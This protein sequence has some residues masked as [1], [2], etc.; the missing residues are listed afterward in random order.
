M[1]LSASAGAQGFEAASIKPS[2]TVS[3]RGC[4][5]RNLRNPRFGGFYEV[6]WN[7]VARD[8]IEPP[9]PAFSGLL[10]D[11]AKRFGINGSSWY[12]ETYEYWHL[13]PVGI[14]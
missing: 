2:Q 6:L 14:N 11:K 13:G 8:G 4:N 12:R 5:C 3:E 1:L 7:V 10:T 9:T